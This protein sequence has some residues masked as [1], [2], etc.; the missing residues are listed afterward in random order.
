MVRRV[1]GTTMRSG[2]R[3]ASGDPPMCPHD[4]SWSNRIGYCTT[5]LHTT[6][7]RERIHLLLPSTH[8][9]IL[10]LIYSI[11]CGVRRGVLDIRFW[12]HHTPG[13]RS[14]FFRFHHRLSLIRATC[15]SGI[16][17]TVWKIRWCLPGYAV[18]TTAHL[19]EEE[20]CITLAFCS[21]PVLSILCL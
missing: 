16:R 19:P 18:L 10:L 5:V 17:R 1:H 3:S 7:R 13:R 21:I 9:G 15:I 20:P 14:K 6:H 4:L 12:T 11:F 2:S 8:I